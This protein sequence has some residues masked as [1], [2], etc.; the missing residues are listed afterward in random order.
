MDWL[1]AFAQTT[2]ITILLSDTDSI[3]KCP[4]NVSPYKKDKRKEK[5][6]NKDK[7]IHQNLCQQVL[8]SGRFSNICNY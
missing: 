1:N 8:E 5:D 7:N 3:Y 4:L 2:Y 6:T